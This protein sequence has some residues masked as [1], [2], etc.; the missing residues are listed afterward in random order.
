MKPPPS[1]IEEITDTE[2]LHPLDTDYTR[3]HIL[4]SGESHWKGG[5]AN[6]PIR[7]KNPLPKSKKK[8]ERKKDRIVQRPGSIRKELLMISGVNGRA[9]YPQNPDEGSPSAEGTQFIPIG[10]H[11]TSI[12]CLFP[13]NC[14][15][16]LH[17]KGLQQ[18]TKL[19]ELLTLQGRAR[20]K[21]H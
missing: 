16:H 17:G 2:R 6:S 20:K 4:L 19:R 15:A 11:T 8:K 14:A 12:C 10:M 7:W 5:I 21:G 1:N 9:S 13:P 18:R 3:V